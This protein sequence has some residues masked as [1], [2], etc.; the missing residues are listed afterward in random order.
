MQSTLPSFISYSNKKFTFSPFTSSLLGV[1]TIAI[2]LIDT[3]G[4]TES[5]TFNIMVVAPLTVASPTSTSSGGTTS[6]STSSTA[7]NTTN[8]SSAATSSSGSPTTSTTPAPVTVINT[9]PLLE[10][11]VIMDGPPP[12][13][14]D[15]TSEDSTATTSSSSSGDSGGSSDSSSSSGSSSNSGGISTTKG[16]SGVGKAKFRTYIDKKTGLRVRIIISKPKVELKARISQ[17]NMKGLM[18]VEF[19]EKVAKPANYTLFNDAFLSLRVIPSDDTKPGENKTLLAW[20]IVAFRDKEM[21]IQL[22]F[23]DPM[24]ISSSMVLLPLSYF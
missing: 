7:T 2:D 12:E 10:G 22:N 6:S 24:V 20:Q 5:Y 16:K 8:S 17:V 18:T 19:S 4:G 9:E 23:T 21:D 14:Y 11:E 3:L 15:G 1:H 13:D